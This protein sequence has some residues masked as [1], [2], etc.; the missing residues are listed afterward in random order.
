M[1]ARWMAGHSKWKTTKHRKEAQDNKKQ[2]MISRHMRSIRNAVAPTKNGDPTLNLKLA[3][4]MD[5][6]Q[7]AGVPKHLV[8]NAIK[9]AMGAGKDAASFEE[10]L[11]EGSGPG[12]SL[13][14]VL[15][16]TDNKMRTAKNVRHIFSKYGGNLGTTNSSLFAFDQVG[17]I[18]LGQPPSDDSSASN[19][20]TENAE[21]KPFDSEKAME[22]AIDGGALD[23]E[24]SEDGKSVDVYCEPGETKNLAKHMAQNGFDP[25][26]S[27][28]T[29]NAK[30]FAD[31][32]MG[33]AEHEEMDVLLEKLEE[34][35]DVNEVYHNA[36]VIEAKQ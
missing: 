30:M 25:V 13:I 17:H 7:A 26:G 32:V 21:Q 12:G 10:Q 4:A 35:D 18:V 6:A 8:Q 19:N 34:L 11:Y 14:L 33:S 3:T 29:Y 23:V 36:Q 28:L 16:E 1:H 5:R 15:T 24:I 2:Q 9:T 27:Q 22:I 31:I 20:S